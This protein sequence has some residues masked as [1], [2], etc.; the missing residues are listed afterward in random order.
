LTPRDGKD[1]YLV[2]H[3]ETGALRVWINE[4]SGGGTGWRFKEIGQIASGLGPGARV[5]IADIDG[6]GVG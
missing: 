4:G 5:R 1:D 3:P 2:L 6:D